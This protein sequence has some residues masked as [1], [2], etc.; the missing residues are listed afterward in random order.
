MTETGFFE[1]TSESDFYLSSQ[2]PRKVPFYGT[3]EQSLY[4]SK[5]ENKNLLNR[6]AEVRSNRLKFK[7]LKI[8]IGQTSRS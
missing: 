2:G 1:D 4:K 7:K 3:L 8:L 5:T 6:M